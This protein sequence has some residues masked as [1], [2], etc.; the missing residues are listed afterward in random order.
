MISASSTFVEYNSP[1]SIASD[2]SHLFF[3]R[4]SPHDCRTVHDGAISLK[5]ILTDR[6]AADGVIESCLDAQVD[7]YTTCCRIDS[8]LRIYAT[9]PLR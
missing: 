7:K 2:V 9:L 4:T 1:L 3:I 5:I 6:T 8:I